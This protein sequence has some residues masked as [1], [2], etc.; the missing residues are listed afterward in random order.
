MRYKFICI[1]IL[2]AFSHTQAQPLLFNWQQ[3][4]GGE[5]GETG[6]SINTIE[7]GYMLFCDT[8]SIDGQVQSNHGKGDFWFIQTDSLGTINW[9]KTYGGSNS[10]FACYGTKCI[11][12]SYFLFGTHS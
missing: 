9:S 2:I 7:T 1:L 8:E 10:E 4:L 5:G 3:C 12:D 11:D 6:I